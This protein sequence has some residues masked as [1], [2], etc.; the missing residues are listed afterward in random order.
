MGVNRGGG[1]GGWGTRSEYGGPTASGNRN[2]AAMFRNSGV[3]F[4]QGGQGVMSSAQSHY[5]PL[6]SSGRPGPRPRTKT[7]PSARQGGPPSSW[8]SSAQK[9]T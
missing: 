6:E 5:G 7:A 4:G 1:G 8:K 2:S 9:G 3:G